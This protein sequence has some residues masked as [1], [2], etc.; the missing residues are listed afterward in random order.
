MNEKVWRLGFGTGVIKIEALEHDGKIKYNMKAFDNYE[1]GFDEV[2]MDKEDL[3]QIR[4]A[5]DEALKV[6]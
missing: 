2:L 5:I 6:K 4:N 1:D 3:L